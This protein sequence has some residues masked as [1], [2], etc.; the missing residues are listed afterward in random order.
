MRR[1]FLTLC[2]L[3][4]LFGSAQ[5]QGDGSLKNYSACSH[6]Y[7]S[8]DSSLLTSQQQVQVRQSATSPSRSSASGVNGAG[9]AENGSYYGEPNANG[10][11]KTVHVNGY[12]RSNGTYVRGHYRSAPGSNPSKK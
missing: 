6:G 10:V 4:L 7:T 8:C 2:C 12:Y 11:P 3:L 5:A 1:I 9:G